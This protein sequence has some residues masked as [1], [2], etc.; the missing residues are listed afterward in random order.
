MFVCRVTDCRFWDSCTE[1]LCFPSPDKYY[2][3]CQRRRVTRG[4]I[5]TVVGV[6]V[7]NSQIRMVILPLVTNSKT[8]M[9]GSG[10]IF[11]Y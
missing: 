2:S 9:M 5:K 8:N 6:I 7:R 1:G 4:C 3:S 10:N 11:V